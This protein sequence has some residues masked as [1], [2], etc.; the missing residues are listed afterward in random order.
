MT[1]GLE[2]EGAGDRT[3]AMARIVGN[4]PSSSLLNVAQ[5]LYRE[6]SDSDLV[7]SISDA[8][9]E[10]RFSSAWVNDEEAIEDARFIIQTARVA[11]EFKSSSIV[12]TRLVSHFF[13]LG[14]AV[15]LGGETEGHAGAHLS[16]YF[17]Q[18]E[19]M[20]EDVKHPI[21]VEFGFVAL[22]Y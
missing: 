6:P 2:L 14:G 10:R 1:G 19:S 20:R 8:V 4:V 12:S 7:I 11:I 3:V 22:S 16:A 13:N 9:L 18:E 21:E 5:Q 17:T 15:I